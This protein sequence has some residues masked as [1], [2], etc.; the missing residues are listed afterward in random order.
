MC[1]RLP[2][3]SGAKAPDGGQAPRC[4]AVFWRLSA[5]RLD[6]RYRPGWC[7]A[8]AAGVEVGALLFCCCNLSKE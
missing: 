2:G 4:Y 6:V 3:E 7:E 8:D 5:I 1:T